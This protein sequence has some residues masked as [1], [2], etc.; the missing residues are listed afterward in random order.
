MFKLR[1]KG[2]LDGNKIVEWENIQES[3]NTAFQTYRAIKEDGNIV[4]AIDVF[5]MPLALAT[6]RSLL[7]FGEIQDQ[8]VPYILHRKTAPWQSLAFT[9]FPTYQIKEQKVDYSTITFQGDLVF[10]EDDFI[11]AKRCLRNPLVTTGYTHV[12]VEWEETEN[13]YDGF[14]KRY[15]TTDDGMFGTGAHHVAFSPR[16]TIH[17][18]RKDPQVDCI[19]FGVITRDK[20]ELVTLTSGEPYDLRVKDIIVPEWLGI[21]LLDINIGDIFPAGGELQFTIYAYSNLGRTDVKDFFTIKFEEVT[22]RDVS[23]QKVSFCVDIH[24]RQAGDILII[25]DKGSYTENI[26]FK[27]LEFQSSTNKMTTK[28]LMENYKYS[29][30][31]TVTMHRTDFHKSFLNTLKVG[32]HVV[33]QHP[34]WSQVTF[35]TEAMETQKRCKCNT[36]WCDFRVDEW[37]FVYVS[38]DVYYLG[39]IAEIYPDSLMFTR[40]MSAPVGSFVIP[41]FPA[42]IK[43]EL[44][45]SFTGERHIKGEVEVMEFREGEYYVPY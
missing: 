34:I 45:T 18:M 30:K 20:K 7:E 35:L 4:E 8:P 3:V 2:Y 39:Q 11:W 42:M 33:F 27:T 31:Y 1:L 22:P 19:N 36:D 13:R 17:Q 6:V 23:Y 12:D 14:L 15:T 29:C 16:T 24:R 38:P 26:E 5:V 28:P 37:A 43:G 44:K 10:F 40:N 41:A 32:K 9:Y 21:T 25:P